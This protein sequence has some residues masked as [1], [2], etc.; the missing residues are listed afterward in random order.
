VKCQYCRQAWESNKYHPDACAFCGAPK[1]EPERINKYDPFFLEGMIVYALSDPSRRYYEWVFYRGDVLVGK[2][3]MTQQEI[4]E[5][6]IGPY[7]DITPY[8]LERLYAE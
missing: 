4:E 2:V 8:M 6:N 7:V 5:L 3:G 1:P